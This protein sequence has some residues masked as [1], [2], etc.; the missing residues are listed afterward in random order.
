[1]Y[2]G[3]CAAYQQGHDIHVKGSP[4]DVTLQMILMYLID[5]DYHE[6]DFLRGGQWYK[7]TFA[8]GERETMTFFAFSKKNMAYR[9][10][11]FKKMIFIPLKKIVKNII[12]SMKLQF[13][14]KLQKTPLSESKTK[15]V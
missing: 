1:L 10:F 3:K 4:S 2:H 11:L 5:N 8:N 9:K 15:K 13:A 6:F 14:K 7:T 12:S